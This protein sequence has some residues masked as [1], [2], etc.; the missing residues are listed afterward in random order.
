MIRIIYFT[1]V[2]YIHSMKLLKTI[3]NKTY[4]LNIK[5]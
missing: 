5:T 1:E 2:T 4:Y 3:K